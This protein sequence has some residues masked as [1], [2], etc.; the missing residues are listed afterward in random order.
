M[1]NVINIFKN[2]FQRILAKKAVIIVAL[3]VIPILIG[4][5]VFFSGRI[6]MKQHIAIVSTHE[7]K[8]PQSDIV[9]VDVLNKKP[10]TSNLLLGKYD[11]IAEEKG[12]GDYEITSIKSKADKQAVENFLKHKKASHDSKEGQ[13]NTGTGTKIL[14][15]ILMIVLMQGVALITLYPEDRTMKTLK[16]VLISPVSEKQYILAQE[17]FTFICLYVPT[18]LAVVV[19]KICFEVEIGFSLGMIGILIAILSALSTA[20]ALF[21]ASALDRDISLVA[22]GIYTITSILAGCFYSFTDNNKILDSICSILPQKAYMTMIKGVENG[23]GIL[24]FKGQLIYLLG[25][26]VVFWLLGSVITNRK[27]KKGIY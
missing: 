23:K 12:N 16:R 26:I 25:W 9:E 24:E 6:M 13:T 22:S 21:F 15:F 4:I 11:A 1:M 3:V 19:T 18:Y 20:L 27:M 7:Y 8:V 10:S 2:N 14:G 5:A 17:I